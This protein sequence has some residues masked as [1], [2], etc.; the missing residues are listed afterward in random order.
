[1]NVYDSILSFHGTWRTYQ[2]RVLESAQRYLDDKKIHIV[3]APGAGKTTLGTSL[4]DFISK[5][6]HTPA[7]VRAN[8]DSLFRRW[9]FAGNVFIQ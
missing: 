7:M 4:S 8:S 6:C 3:A 5:N 2:A 9:P 1:M